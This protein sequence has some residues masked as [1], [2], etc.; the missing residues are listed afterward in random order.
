MSC[1][2]VKVVNVHLDVKNEVITNGHKDHVIALVGAG[3]AVACRFYQPAIS[4]ISE[5]FPKVR[6]LPVDINTNVSLPDLP[7]ADRRVMH[8]NTFAENVY[9]NGTK[10]GERE[11]KGA[12]IAV[13]PSKH[14]GLADL[15]SAHIPVML[16]K[17]M[18][19][20]PD[21]G[22]IAE[23][24]RN[25]PDRIF[26]ADF[27]L[28]SDAVKYLVENPDILNGLG[29]PLKIESTI[30]EPWPVEKGREWLIDDGLGTDII[31][32][33][34]ALAETVLKILN[35]REEITL[36]DVRRNI[37][38]DASGQVPMGKKMNFNET[39]M[40][41]HGHAGKVQVSLEGGKGLDSAFYGAR[42]T[43]S[44][45]VVELCIGTENIFPYILVRKIKDPDNPI[46]YNFPKSGMVGYEGTIGDF[47]RHTYGC[48]TKGPSRARR[49]EVALK[50][51]RLLDEAYGR[52][53]PIEK[54]RLGTYPQGPNPIEISVSPHVQRRV[55]TQL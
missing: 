18:V 22:R 14:N 9:E 49:M 38:M 50:G 8:V 15:L 19:M 1:E 43:F 51:L 53:V 6:L 45:G 7:W 17:P 21:V 48:P 36:D 26:P 29:E 11:I 55:K 47:L 39:Y 37:Y 32:H 28:D 33:T 5:Y 40:L 10:V 12:I 16:E 31:P 54:H 42:I 44:E 30:K 35:I 25:Y 23:L 2:N 4:A 3:G 27:I 24:D 34:H 13:P 52:N 20:P 46:L 41:I